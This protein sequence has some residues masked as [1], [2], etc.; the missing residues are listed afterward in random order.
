MNVRLPSLLTT[1]VAALLLVACGESEP[2]DSGSGSGSGKGT[3]GSDVQKRVEKELEEFVPK[4]DQFGVETFKIV[5]DLKGQETG[6]RTMWVEAYGDRIGIEDQV[7]VYKT[8]EHRLY[9]WDGERSHMKTL[10]DGKVSSMRLRRKDSEPSSFA[11]LPAASLETAGYVR[12]G[13]KDVLGKTCEHW[14]NERFNYEGCRWKRID[15]EFFNGAGTAKIIQ[16]TIATEFVE[17][18]GIPD[19]IKALAE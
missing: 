7:T 2:G 6:T 1:L 5:Y 8:A 4:A 19:R 9:Y 11:T 17:G 15:L 10:P 13:D 18:E 12:I 3:S 14:K 16:S